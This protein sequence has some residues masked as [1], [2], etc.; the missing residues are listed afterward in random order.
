MTLVVRI[1]IT[2]IVLVLIGL[3]WANWRAARNERAAEATYPAEG[4]L[5]L[6]GNQTVHAVVLG[7]GP[8]LVLIHGASGN[9]RD[10]TFAFAKQMSETYRVIVF[11]RPG[12]GWST[13][14]PGDQGSIFDQAR[15]LQKAAAELGATKP[16]VLGH[17]YGGAVAMAWA[18]E[19]PETL[20]ALI[21]LGGA[22]QVWPGGISTF[23]QITG[24]WLGGQTVVPFIA[25]LASE[26]I[27]TDAVAAI[28]APQTPPDGYSAYVGGGLSLRRHTLRI[29]AQERRRL[30]SEIGQMQPRYP[31]IKIPVEIVHG[32]V[33]DTVPVITHAEPL[34]KQ[35]DGAV[36][37]LLEDVGHMPQHADLDAIHAAIDRVAARAGLR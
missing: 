14:L 7:D 27:V 37:T 36:L 28:F 6:L 20:A 17:S 22:T 26:S 32:A 10:M 16:I 33:D 29:N 11:D 1:L 9:T 24:T 15:I 13:P 25:A 5:I 34:S 18:V 23:Y 35:I 19:L 30:K 3:I 21:P 12:F 4:Q 31:Q 2:L 8:D